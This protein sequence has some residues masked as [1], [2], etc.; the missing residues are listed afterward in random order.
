MELKIKENLFDEI[1]GNKAIE[2]G[3][4]V[5]SVFFVFYGVPITLGKCL[6][7]GAILGI[8]ASNFCAIILVIIYILYNKKKLCQKQN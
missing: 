6:V 7:A 1:D 3:G 4:S 5:G 8:A 2:V